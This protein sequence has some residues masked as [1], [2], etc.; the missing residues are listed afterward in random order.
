MV[1]ANETELVS[2]IN[3]LITGHTDTYMPATLLIH[4]TLQ[5]TAYTRG[6][7]FFKNDRVLNTKT[8]DVVYQFMEITLNAF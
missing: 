8:I 2:T 3:L 7:R 6:K 1:K 4:L 5:F